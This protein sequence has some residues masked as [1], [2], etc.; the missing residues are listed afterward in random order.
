MEDYGSTRVKRKGQQDIPNYEQMVAEWLSKNEVKRYRS[1]H[2]GKTTAGV[3]VEE[4]TVELGKN[5]RAFPRSLADL[6]KAPQPRKARKKKD[7]TGEPTTCNID[8]CDRPRGNAR[9]LCTKHYSRLYA[10]EK[11]AGI[12]DN[13]YKKNA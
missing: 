3:E 1:G 9:G 4:P 6:N 10:A 12:F 8:G 7:R 11:K 2:S 5:R 13:R